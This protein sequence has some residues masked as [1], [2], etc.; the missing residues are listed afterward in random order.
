M[1]KILEK[2]EKDIEYQSII[3]DVINNE[4]VKKMKIYNQH[5]NTSCYEHCYN[6]S[7]YCYLISKKL[8]WDYKSSARGAML[9]DLFL[10][11]WRL[12]NGSAG[13][14]AFKHGR[15][16]YENASKIFNLNNI[17]EDI[18]KRHMFPI[19]ITPPKTKEGFLITLVDK[20]CAINEIWQSI[21]EYCSRKMIFRFAVS[22]SNFF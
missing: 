15:I 22:F 12:P 7:Y 2:R 8:H 5:C 13:L 19:T 11:D 18:I 4:E 6:A 14:H 16:A 1:K 21:Y 10:Y 3:K 9:H 17:E 20:Y